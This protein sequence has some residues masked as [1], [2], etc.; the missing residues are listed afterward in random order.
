M[1]I[2][3]G[4]ALA[5]SSSRPKLSK[6]AEHLVN[7]T[8]YQTKELNPKNQYSGL[9]EVLCRSVALFTYAN[10]PSPLLGQGQLVNISL[11]VKNQ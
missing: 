5:A 7:C 1:N 11:K 9:V 10:F 4:P 2:N 8:Y 3:R 6:M